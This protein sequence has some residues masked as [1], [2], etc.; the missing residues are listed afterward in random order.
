MSCIATHHLYKK[1]AVVGD[2]GVSYFVN[3]INNCVQGGIETQSIGST[4]Y[5]VVYSAG[6]S[7]YRETKLFY[8][9]RRTFESSVSTDNNQGIYAGLLEV[10]VSL[11]ATFGS[12]KFFGTR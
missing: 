10:L 2:G 9:D 11:L 6:N 3:C 5:V 12:H 7:D 4:E 8:K 1:E